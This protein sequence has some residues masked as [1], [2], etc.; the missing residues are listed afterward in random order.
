ME[1]PLQFVL[2]LLCF[3]LSGFA[4]LLYETAWAREFESV[5]GTSELAVVSVLAAYMAGLAAGSAVAGRLV[6][7][8]RRPVLWYGLLELGIALTAL[9]V[10]WA[11]RGATWVQTATMGG[12]AVPP[13]AGE[14]SAA[15]FYVAVA[16]AVLIVPTGL[17]GA[18]LP[19]LARHAVRRDEE[20]GR[21]VG[22]LYAVNTLGAVA[23]TSATAF[24]LL[25]A[26]GLRAT[27]YLGAAI[28]A[29]VFAAAAL[30]ARRAALATAGPDAV[31]PAHLTH[32]HWILP[33]VALSGAVSFSYEVL[34]T[35][36][37]GQIVGGTIQGFATMLG[38][39]LL[40]IALGSAVAA[41]LARSRERAVRGFAGAQL[42]TACL[43]LL[44]FLAV[45]RV[46][47]LARAIDAGHAGALAGNAL[48]AALVL[49]PGSLCIGAVFP[50]AVRLLARDEAE[51]G[52]AAARVY[53]WNTVGSIIG[54]LAAGF[55]LVPALGFEGTLSLAVA[56]N[57]GM[58]LVA[59]A[60]FKP[61]ARL[62]AGL[63]VAGLAALAIV[64]PETPWT[65]LR[66]SSMLQNTNAWSGELAYFGVGRSSTVLLLEQRNG[67][68]L[69]TNG[70]PESLIVDDGPTPLDQEP[71]RWLGM[72]PAILRPDLRD[73]LVIGLGGGITVEAVPSSVE[74]ITVIELEEEV[75]S[76]HEWLA[77][78]LGRSPLHDPRVHLVVNDA[79]GALQL[80]DARYGAIVSQ[81][82]HPWTA[83]ASHLYTREFFALAADHLEPGGVFVQ[84][85]GLA[86]VDEALLRSLVAT[87]LDVFPHVAVFRPSPGAVLFAAS[88][89]PID[90]VATAAAA[91]A[92]APED[93]ARFDLR[94][95]EDVAFAWEL[96][97]GDARDFAVGAAVITDDRNP[98]AT[99]SARLG[100][101]TLAG[102]KGG[103]HLFAKYEPLA[104]KQD[105]LDPVYLAL[106][107]AEG[108]A[109]ER[110]LRLAN[111]QSA[112]ATRFTA[113]GWANSVVAPQRAAPAFRRALNEDSTAQS[114]RYGIVSRLRR[115]VE[116]GDA[117]TLALAEPLEGAAAAVVRGWQHA[118][119]GEWS[120]LAA[121]D[122]ALAAAETR[123]PGRRD[124]L[125]LRIEWR[126]A[127]AD[128]TSPSEL[129]ALATELLSDGKGPPDVLLAARAFAAAGAPSGAMDL[130]DYLS[131]MRRRR[132]EQQGALDLLEQLRSGADPEEWATVRRRLQP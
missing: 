21:R 75:V 35:R 89:E 100:R 46:P 56:L 88:D 59:A 111:A 34:W 121:L 95:P 128:A 132:V 103:D 129:T 122:G 47:E 85:I 33:L 22:T 106:R 1:A 83:G 127:T 53:A 72:L 28:N 29:L 12:R 119:A 45:G 24:V 107:L 26:M 80:T 81:P 70:L 5:F 57:L 9:A 98:L 99:R 37:I 2:L 17:M 93:F 125:R 109:G 104:A 48:I 13:S 64:R 39:F 76:A 14:V 118:A 71:A 116:A 15:F 124:A 6:T 4:A 67:W 40:G 63:A 105:G 60:A 16:F 131:R 114:A 38:S 20:V 90:P 87:L 30:L 18:T 74:T 23:G 42:G 55:F 113:L 58:A 78:R 73:V 3:F 82:S 126:V 120:E 31:R 11:I 41:R 65:V 123:D 61:T 50:F 110:A 7:R 86:F 10:P 117:E 51:A 91:F 8:I 108:G 97:E 25:P 32:F 130:L 77:D 101:N 92:A 102:G 69:T 84:W 54:A 27:V 68:R 19:L 52:P 115:R 112:P 62:V 79:R 44:A 49:L 66:H 96:D 43:S 94:I 36:L